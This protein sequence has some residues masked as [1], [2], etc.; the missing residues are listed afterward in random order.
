MKKI[1]TV[2][3]LAFLPVVASAQ[4]IGRTYIDSI[5][6]YAKDLLDVALPFI[7]ALSVVWFV[8]NIFAYVVRGGEEA[9]EAAKTHILWGIIGLF[10]MVSVWGI[11]KVVAGIF[12]VEQGG[13]A[14][15]IPTLPRK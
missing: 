15:Q 3:S 1:I 8:W 10:V 4:Q 7:I 11:V 12:N 6:N 13:S 5:I 9:K 14:A 2:L